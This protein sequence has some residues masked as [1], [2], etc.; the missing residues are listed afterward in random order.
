[1]RIPAINHFYVDVDS[2]VQ[3]VPNQY[4]A[5]YKAELI[6]DGLIREIERYIFIDCAERK[7]KV[8]KTIKYLRDGMIDETGEEDLENVPPNDTMAGIL[9]F[10]CTY[11]KDISDMPRKEDE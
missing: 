1:M 3:V 6:S 8:L 4:N 9:Q 10:V 11:K 2:V 5:C 7:T